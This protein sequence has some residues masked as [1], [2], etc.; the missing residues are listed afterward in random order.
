MKV[1]ILAIVI[2][3]LCMI[4]KHIRPEYALI[5]QLCGVVVLVLFLMSSFDDVVASLEELISGSGIDSS[6]LGLLLKALS[7]SILTD[8]AASICRDSGNNTLANGV[9]LAGKTVIV[10]LTL[11]ILKKLAE[12]AIGFI[13]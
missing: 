7:F 9:E 11:P 12:A 4:L 2:A 3:F 8:I 13:K 1:F 10:V 5:C 6:F